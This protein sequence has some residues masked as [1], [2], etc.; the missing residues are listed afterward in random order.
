[1]DSNIQSGSLLRSPSV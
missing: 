1:M